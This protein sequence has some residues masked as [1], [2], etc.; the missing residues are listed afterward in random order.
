MLCYNHSLALLFL[1]DER[2]SG[3][4]FL[5]ILHYIFSEQS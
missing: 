3:N 2:A 5:R 4:K 1:T